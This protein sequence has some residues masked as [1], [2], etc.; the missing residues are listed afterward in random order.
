MEKTS[1]NNQRNRR[2]GF[3]LIE[4]LLVVVII[5]ILAAVAVPKLTGRVKQ[6][7]IGAAKGSISGMGV[8]VDLYETDN[9]NLPDSLNALVTKGAEPNWNGP[10]L[11]DAKV[12]NDP[13]GTAFQYTKKDNA[14]EIRSA[15]PDKSFGTDD[16]VTK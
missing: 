5:G 4:V 6:S 9:G 8:S 10:Y 11:K 15:G 12:P 1:C 13:W 3:T 16:D 7:Q 2:A 14:Y